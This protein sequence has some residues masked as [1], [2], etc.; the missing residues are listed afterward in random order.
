MW[1]YAAVGCAM[2]SLLVG[3]GFVLAWTAMN[4]V[5]PPSSAAAQS[6][7]PSLDI[8]AGASHGAATVKLAAGDPTV[9][10]LKLVD[11]KGSPVVRARPDGEASVP[12]GDYT[13]RVKVVARPVLETSVSINEDT[14]L[15]CKPATMGR[16]RCINAAG[17]TAVV[18]QP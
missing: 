12:V 16:V 3:I 1:A 5:E 17:V 15:R 14:T 13:L 9:Q 2:V 4:S 8:V 6:D 11:G 18:L 7:N 10:W